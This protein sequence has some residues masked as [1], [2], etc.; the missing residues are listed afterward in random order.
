M[1][2]C[3]CHLV[4]VDPVNVQSRYVLVPLHL[5]ALTLQGEEGAKVLQPMLYLTDS[6]VRERTVEAGLCL[7]EF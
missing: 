2:A 5:L 3:I 6:D 4:N 7:E 1:Y